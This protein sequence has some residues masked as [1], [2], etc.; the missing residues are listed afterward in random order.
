MNKKEL[1]KKVS[2]ETGLKK[3]K[4]RFAVDMAFELISQELIK[5]NSI[6]IE[7]FGKFLFRNNGCEIFNDGSFINIEPPS[8]KIIFIKDKES[9]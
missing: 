8:Y 4:C 7:S 2:E 6:E 5:G 9:K 1:V 3:K